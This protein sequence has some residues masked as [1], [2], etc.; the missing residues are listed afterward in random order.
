MK[1]CAEHTGARHKERRKQKIYMQVKL[2]TLPVFVNDTS[3]EDLNFF[4]RSVRVLEIKKEFVNASSGQYWVF[5][6]TYL[7]ISG[8]VS[9]NVNL[10]QERREKVDY[11]NVL[12]ETEFERFTLLRKI[13]KQIAEDDAVP[14]YAVF[15]DAELAGLSKIE[16]LNPSAMQK[17][18]GIGKKKVEKYGNWVC[19][20]LEETSNIALDEKSGQP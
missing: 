15:T 14:P 8:S 7:P 13:R 19:R 20:I 10:P 3:V 6:I 11:K 18:D 9:A 16:N 12:T 4:L 17:I 1:G 2:F 5:C